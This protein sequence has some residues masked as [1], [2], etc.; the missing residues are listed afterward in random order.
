MERLTWLALLFAS[1][2]LPSAPVRATGSDAA[3]S[4]PQAFA[5]A[6]AYQQSRRPKDAEVLLDALTHDPDPEIRAEARFRLGQLRM[7]LGKY[8]SAAEAFTALLEE[9]PDAQPARLALAQALAMEGKSGAAARQLRRAQAAGLPEDVQRLVDG[10]SDVLRR[11]RPYGVNF[12]LGIAPDSNINQAT[13]AR[14]LDIG[15]FPLVLDAAGRATSGVGITASADA[16]ATVPLG[17]RTSLVSRIAGIGSFYRQDQF[18]DLLVSAST[19]PEVT[20]GRVVLRPAATYSWR[21]FGGRRYSQALGGSLDLLAPAGKTAQVGATITISD[22]HY[23]NAEQDGLQLTA[24][25]TYEKAL[26]TRLYGRLRAT[27]QRVNAKSDAYATTSF[28]GDASL[29]R[30]VG[31]ATLFVDGSYLRT[32]ADGKFLLFE[33]ARRDD[34]VDLSVGAAWKRL[35]F[36]GLTPVVRLQQTINRSPLAIY[37][38]KRTRVEFALR[39]QL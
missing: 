16:F 27:I 33:G 32:T 36:L 21:Q 37:Q 11:T 34:R 25:A 38:F 3:L 8:A 23:R 9:K 28:G 35:S 39:E 24:S 2:I 30:F 1:A 4:A 29:S 26:S 10:F 5:L 6:E 7:K 15:G 14:T 17:S 13:N 12:E 31:A 22:P 20:I 19:G 18:N